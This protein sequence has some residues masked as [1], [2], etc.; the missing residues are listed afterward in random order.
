MVSNWTHFLSYVVV[1]LL[2]Q[3]NEAV[4]VVHCDFGKVFN[5]FLRYDG[6]Y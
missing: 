6:L 2:E 1:W 5:S 3:R 4:A